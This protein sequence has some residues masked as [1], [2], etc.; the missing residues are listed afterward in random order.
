MFWIAQMG[1]QSTKKIV[2]HKMPSSATILLAENWLL[3]KTSYP[4]TFVQSSVSRLQSIFE[5]LQL[6]EFLVLS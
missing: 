3:G 2:R 1:D 6:E 5:M 4:L